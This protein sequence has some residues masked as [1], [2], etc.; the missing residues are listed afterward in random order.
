[1]GFLEASS[2]WFQEEGEVVG[3][4]VRLPVT[5]D[6]VSLVNHTPNQPHSTGLLSLT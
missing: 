1:M 6:H 3:D 5:V 2:L 4:P